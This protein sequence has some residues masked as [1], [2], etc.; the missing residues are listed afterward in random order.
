[1][2][3]TLATLVLLHAWESPPPPPPTDAER[4]LWRYEQCLWQDTEAERASAP[5]S[6]ARART[7]VARAAAACLA[8]KAEARRQMLAKT[9]ENLQRGPLP[10][11]EF[12]ES[13]LV[14]HLQKPKAAHAPN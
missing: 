2:I 3:A 6:S 5:V 14:D 4:A 12:Y 13:H 1:M 9:L 8:E 10:G 7:L 11:P